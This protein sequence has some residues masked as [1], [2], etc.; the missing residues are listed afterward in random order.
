MDRLDTRLPVTLLTGALGS[1]KTTLLNRILTE[2][3]GIKF[4]VIVNE[5]G[6]LSIDHHLVVGTD[7]QVVELANGCVC[8]TV[9]EDLLDA[10]TRI[11]KKPGGVEYL[12][13]ETTGLADPRPVA[14]TFLHE[15]LCDDVR[16]DAIL[17]VLDAA[18]FHDNLL[19]SGTTIDQILAG[20][21][22]LLNKVDLVGDAMRQKIKEEIGDLNPAARL[23]ETVNAEVDLRLILDVDVHR[24]ATLDSSVAGPQSGATSSEEADA[25]GGD[26]VSLAK[27]SATAK[28]AGSHLS[29][30]E[31]SSVSFT[32]EHPFDYE[33]LGEFLETLPQNIFRGKGLLWIDGYDDQLLFH[34]VGDR[35]TATLH[36]PW[37]AGARRSKLVLIGKQ[38]DQE[39]LLAQLDACLLKK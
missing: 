5:F 15:D 34:L 14:Q 17:T 10:M 29:R 6:E 24:A 30:E 26:F 3:H 9:R 22:L 2:Q 11:L 13:V 18:N 19:R 23:L 25:E 32:T 20:D 12:L 4:G 8:C 35:S 36:H 16:L 1:G 28:T 21:I 38:L 31:I 39:L 27:L 37:P 33:R 7:E